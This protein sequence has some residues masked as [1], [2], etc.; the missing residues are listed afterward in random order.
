MENYMQKS[1]F[2]NSILIATTI[3]ALPIMG[4]ELA[5]DTPKTPTTIN[6]ELHLTKAKRLFTCHDK[7]DE[8]YCKV[9]GINWEENNNT[10]I[11]EYAL[12]KNSGESDYTC[13]TD[14]IPKNL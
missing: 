14:A 10:H 13:W 2:I 3:I 5:S 12:F 4:M 7:Y 1:S 9:L 6:V 11:V 8:H